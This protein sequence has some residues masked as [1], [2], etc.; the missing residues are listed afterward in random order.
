MMRTVL[1]TFSCLALSGCLQSVKE[2][3]QAP[4]LSAIGSGLRGDEFA[5]S[6][7]SSKIQSQYKDSLAFSTWTNREGD[8]FADK[9]AIERGDILTVLIS[10][11]DRAQLTN[12]SD[13]RR[14]SGRG[15]G[16]SGDYNIG[17]VGNSA[18]ADGNINS[19]SDFKGSGGTARAETISLSVAA[20]VTRVLGNGNLVVKGTQEVRVNSEL[21]VL[22]IAG[23]VRPNDIGPN[24]T[25]SYERIAEARVSYGGRGHISHAQSPPYGQQILN[26]I[27]PF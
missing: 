18:E 20:V 12:K 7:P 10:I 26:R 23:I 13:S 21:R 6:I 24:N 4:H 2:I 8:L 5:A 16:L 14:T 27:L 15:I 1:L 9:L 17:G 11:N 3:G 19:T 25:I 22:T